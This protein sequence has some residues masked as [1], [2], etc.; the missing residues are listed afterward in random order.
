[1]S[2]KSPSA[3]HRSKIPPIHLNQNENNFPLCI[4][5]NELINTPRAPC[6]LW[7]IMFNVCYLI[8]VY[9]KSSLALNT[10][11]AGVRMGRRGSDFCSW[12]LWSECVLFLKEVL[13]TLSDLKK[14]DQRLIEDNRLSLSL[15][16]IKAKRIKRDFSLSLKTQ[17]P[18]SLLHHFPIC[19]PVIIIKSLIEPD[20]SVQ[21]LIHIDKTRAAAANKSSLLSAAHTFTLLF[22]GLIRDFNVESRSNNGHTIRHWT[23]FREF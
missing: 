5:H 14:E 15:S 13:K 9:A 16:L 1:M 19:P 8:V 3:N 7:P 21:I 2:I 10:Q 12:K 6:D 11:K 22:R 4:T 18:L 23:S 20:Q 17:F